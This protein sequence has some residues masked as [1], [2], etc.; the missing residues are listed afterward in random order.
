MEKEY[1]LIELTEKI[2]KIT[3]KTIFIIELAVVEKNS[4]IDGYYS[5]N[6][7]HSEDN[8]LF[9]YEKSLTTQSFFLNNSEE[10]KT[11]NLND[12]DLILMKENNKIIRVYVAKDYAKK[13][14]MSDFWC[15]YAKED[16][17]ND[18]SIAFTFSH[19]EF[20]SFIQNNNYDNDSAL[21]PYD[22]KEIQLVERTGVIIV[23]KG[24]VTFGWQT[25]TGRFNRLIDGV[26]IYISFDDFGKIQIIKTLSNY[27]LT[28]NVI[29]EYAFE[30][31]P[32]KPLNRSERN[33]TISV[34]FPKWSS[35]NKSIPAISSQWSLLFGRFL[36]RVDFN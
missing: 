7:Q 13:R 29:V 28:D 10:I 18:E 4:V 25:S 3:N 17:E 27:A 2:D 11:I 8:D 20:S 23:G 33:L 9:L 24:K 22:A 31:T 15:A 19:N 16:L 35:E 26:I 5:F 6:S 21:I 30:N 36:G 12:F 34:R 1:R 32:L 14:L